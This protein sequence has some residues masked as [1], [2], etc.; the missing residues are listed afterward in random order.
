MNT[1][2]RHTLL[3]YVPCIQKAC[4]LLQVTIGP[5]AALSNQWTK[6]LNRG[7][8]GSTPKMRRKEKKKATKKDIHIKI[9]C[10]K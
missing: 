2:S 4:I 1:Q 5:K 9:I 8:E 10:R 6:H 7:T 3:P